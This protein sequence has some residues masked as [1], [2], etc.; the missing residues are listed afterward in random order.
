MPDE[1][2]SGPLSISMDTT[3]V[4]TSVPVIADGQYA[5]WKLVKFT[6]QQKEP[7]E[8]S[9]GGPVFKF[10]LDLQNPVPTTTGHTLKPGDFGSKFFYNI[11]LFDKNT[12]EGQIPDRSKQAVAAL[13]DAV[14][15]TGVPGNP[16]GRPA[17]PAFDEACLAAMMHQTF[18]AKMKAKTGDYVGNE[19]A[20]VLNEQ[21][22]PK[23]TV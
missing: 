3:T 8:K 16:K 10:E 1:N 17:R 21:D 6:Q 11:Y 22:M 2:Q 15:G 9:K 12:P 14:L 13:Q 18:W 7:S 5:K 23:G 20:L 19:I 4:E